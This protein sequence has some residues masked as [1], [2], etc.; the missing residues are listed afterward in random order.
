M[1]GAC[2]LLR[3]GASVGGAELQRSAWWFLA[4]E[5]QMQGP[6]RGGRGLSVL[7][8]SLTVFWW[9]FFANKAGSE[10]LKLAGRHVRVE[11]RFQ[12]PGPKPKRA[13]VTFPASFF[14]AATP[15]C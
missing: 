3:G 12:E 14:V 4:R 7:G 1:G 9:G 2:G 11:R 15:L 6:E 5:K 10:S 8:S 13:L